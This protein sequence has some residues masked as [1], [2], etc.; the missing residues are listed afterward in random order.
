M[1]EDL[2]IALDIFENINLA[3]RLMGNLGTLVRVTYGKE[4]TLLMD[5]REGIKAAI[6][7]FMDALNAID[8]RANTGIRMEE[9]E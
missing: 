6:D 9:A 5:A 3:K 1:K 7:S 8:D 4:L 2:L